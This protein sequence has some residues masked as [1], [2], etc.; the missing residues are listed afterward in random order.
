MISNKMKLS[1]LCLVIA[2]VASACS[3]S[4][5]EPQAE[6]AVT[7]AAEV[8]L[9]G[10]EEPAVPAAEEPA[11]DTAA[12]SKPSESEVT[13]S[14]AS[15]QPRNGKAEAPVELQLS[16]EA[17][18]GETAAALRVTTLTDVPQVVALFKLPPSV[19]LVAGD[20]VQ[21]LGAMKANES[22]TVSV[23]VNIP[24]GAQGNLVGAAELHLT[25]GVRLSKASVL[26]LGSD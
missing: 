3:R 8:E 18:S 9:E 20:L 26:K 24:V 25:K 12:K 22:R 6:T 11:T 13:T 16:T 2:V 17:P 23:T 4:N 19:Q 5:G 21:Q 14:P 1:I 10:S 7:V 15:N